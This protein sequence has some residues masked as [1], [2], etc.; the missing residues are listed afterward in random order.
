MVAFMKCLYTSIHLV[1]TY[2][3]R[4]RWATFQS[5]EY[6]VPS[7]KLGPLGTARAWPAPAGSHAHGK[8]ARHVLYSGFTPAS[9]LVASIPPSPM[10]ST[11]E[12]GTITI[13]PFSLM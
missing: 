2:G 6:R 13:A 10:V 8:P 9:E 7:W 3:P 5:G 4:S 11:A 12:D 1:G